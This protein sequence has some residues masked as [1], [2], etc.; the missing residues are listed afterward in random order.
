VGDKGAER[1]HG[2]GKPIRD[3]TVKNPKETEKEQGKGE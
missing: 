2:K 1:E 3:K